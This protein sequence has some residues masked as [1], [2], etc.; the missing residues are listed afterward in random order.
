MKFRRIRK[1]FGCS[2][3]KTA[4]AVVDADAPPEAAPVEQDV[5]NSMEGEMEDVSISVQ[6]G[7]DAE[8]EKMVVEDALPP[9]IEEAESVEVTEDEH[10]LEMS[11]QNVGATCC[12]FTMFN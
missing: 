1:T 4:D 10:A 5:S 9:P 11:A 8:E 7:S 6:E 2:S 12:G 3:K